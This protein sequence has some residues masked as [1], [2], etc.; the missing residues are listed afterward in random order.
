MFIQ[1]LDEDVVSSRLKKFACSRDSDREDF[2]HNKAVL[3][4]KRGMARSYLAIEDG[5]I[6]GYFTLSI[7][8]MQVP[9]GQ[10]ESNSLRKRMNIDPDN[11]VAQTFLLGQLGR[12]DCS[13]K[14][15][16]VELLEDA[17]SYVR[18]A[19][20]IV[21][22]RVLRVDCTNDLIPYYERHGFTYI[23]TTEPTA[24]K[25][26]IN[27]MIQILRLCPIYSFRHA[28]VLVSYQL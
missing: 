17:L 25:N 9:E 26:P 22:C 3:F 2:L 4:E 10:P 8:C 23:H 21:G 12:A 14:G 19:N 5:S 6:V 7:R 27:Q 28:S 24:T 11:G 13:C 20:E 16:G 1:R 18:R 15:L